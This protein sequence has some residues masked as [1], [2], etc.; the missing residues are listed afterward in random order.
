M[1]K[2]IL[3]N[4]E[5][6]NAP[7][8]GITEIVLSTYDPNVFTP[9]VATISVVFARFIIVSNIRNDTAQAL[10]CRR[11]FTAHKQPQVVG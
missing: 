11:R 6:K 7:R 5:T 9:G 3:S 10:S 4:T 1:T 8:I 2:T